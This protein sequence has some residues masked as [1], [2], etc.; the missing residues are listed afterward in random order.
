MD[1]DNL[2]P[3]NFKKITI[4]NRKLFFDS[5]KVL[6]FGIKGSGKTYL[7]RNYLNE[8]KKSEF[9]YI[10]LGDFRIKKEN[11]K[12]NIELFTEKNRA[13][14]LIVLDNFEFDFKLPE[15]DNL[16]VTSSIYKKLDSFE[17]KELFPL[18]FEEYLSF[19]IRHQDTIISFNN[20][21]KDG[22]FPEI[23]FANRY[24]KTLKLQNIIKSLTKSE[25]ELSILKNYLLYQGYPISIFQI[26]N[27]TKKEIKISKD[28]FYEVTKRF[29]DSKILYF[30]E[31]HRAKNIN[32]KLYLVDFK[33]RSAISFSKEF[34]KEFENMIFLKLIKRL[35]EP[36]YSDKIEF[37]LPKEK[38]AIL[39]TPFILEESLKTKLN[40]IDEEALK[41][42]IKNIK[43]ITV[44]FEFKL[45]YRGLK[46]EA[47]PFWMWAVED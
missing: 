5:K 16:I 24:D 2:Y 36:F 25:S 41:F 1:L 20:Y 30:M 6:I 8:F 44:N 46:V 37:I 38:L 29:I 18:D 7:V 4:F 11:L 39:S 15:F 28:K 42:D 33:M 14:K 34:P 23:F 32:K 26:F 43:F 45:E 12:S 27:N 3:V 47:I 21:L 31:K 17:F 19:D 35:K 13:I 10:N 9:L 40:S 22:T